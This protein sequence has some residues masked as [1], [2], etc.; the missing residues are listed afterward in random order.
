MTKRTAKMAI[1]RLQGEYVKFAKNSDITAR[2]DEVYYHNLLIA[3]VDDHG[4]TNRLI[5]SLQNFKTE[6]KLRQAKRDLVKAAVDVGYE[7][8][9][10]PELDLGFGV[11]E[12]H[13]C[14]ESTIETILIEVAKHS[15]EDIKTAAI[16]Y[17]ENEDGT[18]K[19]L[20]LAFNQKDTYEYDNSVI[21]AE[22]VLCNYIVDLE[23]YGDEKL[24]Y[25][26]LLEPCEKCLKRMIANQACGIYYFVNHKAKWDTIGYLQLCNDIWNKTI[27]QN[28][29]ETPI[30]YQGICGFKANKFMEKCKEKSK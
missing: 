24:R 12:S 6:P 5:V 28:Y 30:R 3:K 17:V 4:Y 22:Q 11:E 13:D 10:V 20:G 19:I 2:N 1:D 18:H 26:S 21:H 16:A 27:L 7:I 14:S 29:Y 25:Y 23:L 15:E 9:F 8:I